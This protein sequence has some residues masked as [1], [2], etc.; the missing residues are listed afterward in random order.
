[1]FE[2]PKI[3]TPPEQNPQRLI[4]AGALSALLI[5]IATLVY[6]Y[7]QNTA[8]PVTSDALKTLNE[9]TRIN[10]C[11][12]ARIVTPPLAPAL[13]QA[14]IPAEIEGKTSIN[15][16][17]LI[18][19]NRDTV[20]GKWTRT[21]QGICSDSRGIA[22]LQIPYE[23]PAEY[24]LALVFT[25]TSGSGEI[26]IILKHKDSR[27]FRWIMGGW[28][29]RVFG[30]DMINGRYASEN[31]NPTG[32]TIESGAL[33]NNVQYTLLIEVRNDGLR[34][35]LDGNLVSQRKTDFSDM[36]LW[37]RYTLPDYRALGIASL[38]AAL[39]VH[40]FTLTPVAGNG[41]LLQNERDQPR[42]NQPGKSIDQF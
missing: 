6:Y 16:A 36:T 25:R 3:F 10:V 42:E 39:V 30:F 11:D 17:N 21:A 22:I 18:A 32:K 13:P 15:L 40:N 20:A 12:N 31:E 27:Q 33:Q 26:C 29:N 35:F 23:V 9:K 38:Q 4:I 8:L 34:A 37:Q 5:W 1:V 14:A 19:I 28:N 24:D 7:L 41:K 2:P